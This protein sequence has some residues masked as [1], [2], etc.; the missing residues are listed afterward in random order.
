MTTALSGPSTSHSASGFG[1]MLR[2]WRRARG[3]SQLDLALHCGLSQRHLSFLESGRS[4]IRPGL[5]A[6]AV[7][8]SAGSQAA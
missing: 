8:D 5:S 2:Q 7:P 6:A 4:P 1:T 3:A